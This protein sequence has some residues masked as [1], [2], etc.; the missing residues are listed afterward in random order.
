M[1]ILGATEKWEAMTYGFSSDSGLSA[2]RKFM[3]VTDYYDH[4]PREILAY[5]DENI[6]SASYGASFPGTVNCFLTEQSVTRM[7]DS[8]EVFEVVLSYKSIRTDKEKN[9]NLKPLDRPATIEWINAKTMKTHRAVIYRSD[10]YKTYSQSVGNSKSVKSCT[11]SAGDFFEPVLEYAHN[12]WTAVIKKNVG[13]IPT[14]FLDYEDAVNDADFTL[15]FYGKSV[16][17]PRGCAKLSGILMPL[18]KEED[19]QTFVELSFQIATRQFRDRRQGESVVPEPWDEELPD[20]GT[21]IY[22]DIP[23]TGSSGST[24]K[25]KRGWQQV[26]DVDLIP[27]ALPVP[28]DG[29]GKNILASPGTGRIQESDLVYSLVSPYFRRDFSVL[30]IR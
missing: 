27:V 23:V 28:F 25:T 3:V 4:N 14:W 11:N 20:M 18:P 19:E 26:K 13:E 24:N 29:K 16:V 2:S 6:P 9:R 8:R 22:G 15:A 21:R 7:A 10:Y 30:P 1:T 5:L 12:E 17:I